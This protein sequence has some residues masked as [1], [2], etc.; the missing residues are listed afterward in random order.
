MAIEYKLPYTA[1]EIANKL[2]QIDDKLDATALDSA[3]ETALAEAKASGEFDGKDGK[4]G[5]D[6]VNGDTPYIKNDSW[7]IGEVNTG[8]KAQGIDGV[9]GFNGQD[10]D[11]AYDIAKKNGFDGTEEEWL[12]SLKGE[13][14]LDGQD[15][16]S[17]THSWDGTTLI[18]TSA[19]GTSSANL[20]GNP[21]AQG[22]KGEKGDKGDKGET[23]AQGEKGDKGEK[24][25]DGYIPIKGTDYWTEADKDEI[26]EYVKDEIPTNISELIN[27]TGYLTSV[28]SEYITETELNAKGYLT[29]VELTSEQLKDIA[30]DVAEAQ[31]MEIVNSTEEMVDTTK[32]YICNGFVYS[33]MRKNL[34]D[35]TIEGDTGWLQGQRITNPGSGTN[36]ITSEYSSS[37]STVSNI[38]PCTNG[39]II[40][41]KGATFREN[42]DRI[43]ILYT[44]AEGNN[45]MSVGY[46][47]VGITISGQM[48][49]KSADSTMTSEFISFEITN[50]QPGVYGFR[51]AMKT[52]VPYDLSNIIVYK[53]TRDNQDQIVPSL[54]WVNT[55]V[56][57]SSKDYGEDI[58]KIETDIKIL[59]ETNQTLKDKIENIG[60]TE[61]PDYWQEHLDLKIT[62]IKELHKQY[63]KNCFSFVLM[64][65]THYPS[66]IGKISP[67]LARYIMDK[68]NIKYALHA[69]DYQTRG[70]HNTKEALLKENEDVEKMF[71]PIMN[72]VL[73]QQGNHDGAYGLLDR[74]GDGKITNTY[75]IVES[76]PT[77][78]IKT[79]EP[80]ALLIANSN[81]VRYDLM[82]YIEG[83]WTKIAE[84]VWNLNKP[85][86]DFESY[87]HNLTH[88]ELHEYIYRKVGMVGNVHFDDTGTAYYIDD[89]SNNVRYIG[90][91]TQCNDYELREDDTQKYPKMWSMNFT[92]PQ[93]DFLINEALIKDVTDKTKIIVFGHVPTTQE[94]G[95]RDVMNDVLRAFKGRASIDERSY[96]GT[97]DYYNV[98]LKDINF[99]NAK[100]TLVG[101]FHGHTHI[102]SVNTSQGF[103]IIGTRCDAHEES[104]SSS[105][106]IERNGQ[107]GTI[108]EQSF[109]VFTITNDTIYRTKIGAGGFDVD[110]E[111]KP[112]AHLGAQ[113]IS[114]Y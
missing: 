108:Y 52:P 55:G 63:G 107:E 72:R 96:I 13:Y 50:V 109:D 99:S 82:Q 25:Q 21:G 11:S 51:F 45:V 5:K 41:I 94:I 91:N 114:T 92:Q 83:S 78:D 27:D 53:A 58:S 14:G 19:S 18:I 59:K 61:I 34:S 28:P 4:D 77:E 65:D 102:D 98:T 89:T 113:Q 80:Y 2:G 75:D 15:G 1:S 16:I 95:D 48:A 74:N 104:H 3:I 111:G 73:W 71:A 90:L 39:D 26:K 88:G 33:Y 93:F 56:S 57:A 110:A 17:A 70:C 7:W 68:T 105:E 23:G 49:A 36:G 32:N 87:V 47:N 97:S 22:D 66:N 29:E 106:Y 42:S 10:G 100:G 69:G 46:T 79:N 67:L 103:N 101:Y 84:S 12:N 81:P 8:V 20:K 54:E 6:G 62:A 86:D 40:Q 85:V 30:S 64:T 44:N 76:L 35:P 31:K 60:T 37:P 43:A 24:G 112:I 38:I 9:D